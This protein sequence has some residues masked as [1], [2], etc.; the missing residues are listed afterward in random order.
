[1]SDPELLLWVFATLIDTILYTYPIFI[2]PL[3]LQEQEQYYQES[4]TIGHLL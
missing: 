1:A 3:S 4:K 2:G